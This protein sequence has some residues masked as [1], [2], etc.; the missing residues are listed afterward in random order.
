MSHHH[1]VGEPH[2]SPTISPFLLRM[3]AP[4]RLALAGVLIALIW[5]AAL[6]VT[7]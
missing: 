6:L 1:H 4:R 3:S 5:G 2:P 7:R